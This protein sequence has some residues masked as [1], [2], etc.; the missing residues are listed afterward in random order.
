MERLDF[1]YYSDI[2]NKLLQKYKMSQKIREINLHKKKTMAELQKDQ[3]ERLSQE[4]M[5]H[6]NHLKDEIMSDVNPM[7]LPDSHQNRA[8]RAF[9]DILTHKADDDY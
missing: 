6:V 9:S 8:G 1:A 2:L 4:M 7:T 3:A 5:H